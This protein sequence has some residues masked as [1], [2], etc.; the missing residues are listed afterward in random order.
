MLPFRNIHTLVFDFDGVFTDNLVYINDLGEE[1]V[2]CS[3]ADSYGISILKSLKQ[4]QYSFLDFFVLSTEKSKVV[5]E[6]CKKMGLTVFS[7]VDNKK[8]FL[9]NWI[10]NDPRQYHDALNGV[11]YFG[12][13][14]NDLAIMRL[15]GTTFAPKDAHS[16]IKEIA[17]FNLNSVGGQGFVR[18]GIELTLGIST[19]SQE[20]INEFIS[21][22]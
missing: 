16:A 22:C 8:E 4:V 6:R 14:L 2:R 3:R 13:D 17:T 11:A 1:S 10:Q 21:N 12:N 9:E 15:C 7:G 5:A 18:E 20:E 19:M